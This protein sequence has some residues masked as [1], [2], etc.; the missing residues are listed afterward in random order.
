MKKLLVT[1]FLVAL[2][3]RAALAAEE[4]YRLLQKKKLLLKRLIQLK[5]KL[6]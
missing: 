2:A 3:P 1:L 4:G 5:L 6:K